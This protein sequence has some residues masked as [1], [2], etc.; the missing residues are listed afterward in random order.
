MGDNQKEDDVPGELPALGDVAGNSPGGEAIPEELPNL[1]A[2]AASAPKQNTSAGDGEEASAAS[3]ASADADKI[4]SIKPSQYQNNIANMPGVSSTDY[5]SFFSE[6]VNPGSSAINGNLLSAMKKYWDK[7]RLLEVP[8]QSEIVN[9]TEAAI[10]S[11][12]S[13][14]KELERVW[15]AKMKDFNVLKQNIAYLEI[16]IASHSEELANL[17]KSTNH[18]RFVKQMNKLKKGQKSRPAKASSAKKRR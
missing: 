14:L 9:E 15:L 5:P 10:Q 6:A 4:T 11:E 8:H 13:K 3:Q 16:E 7:N 1:D 2:P 17:L 18:Q 12:V